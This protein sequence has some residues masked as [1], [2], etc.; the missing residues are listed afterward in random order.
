M[1]PPA[2]AIENNKCCWLMRTLRTKNSVL[3]TTSNLYP[4][5]NSGARSHLH[6]WTHQP[7]GQ[8]D[9]TEEG[10]T[11]RQLQWIHHRWLCL[12]CR[13]SHLQNANG[14]VTKQETKHPRRQERSPTTRWIQE[15]DCSV[16]GLGLDMACTYQQ[17]HQQAL[18]HNVPFIFGG[19][20]NG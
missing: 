16:R 5:T 6:G 12:R 14:A 17:D 9:T 2:E 18:M 11:V 10:Q 8:T 7:I 20:T 15:L 19:A 1:A 4:I 3:S 13:L